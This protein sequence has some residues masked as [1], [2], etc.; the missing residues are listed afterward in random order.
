M[1]NKNSNIKQRF[2][3]L[4]ILLGF[5]YS[6]S[7]GQQ[8]V[9]KQQ[10]YEKILTAASQ[11]EKYI[12]QLKNKKIGLV[13]NQTSL[14]NDSVHL[15]DYLLN[16]NINVVKIFSPEHGFR[17][18]AADGEQ[19]MNSKDVKTGLPIVSLYGATKK[20]T[21][22]MLQGLDLIIFDIQDVGT[23]F[24]TYI[25]TMHYVM[26][27]CAPRGIKVMILDRPNP[28]GFYVD[29]P[30]ME[31]EFMS[32]VGMHK[33]P[34]VH[35]MT[36][37]ELAMMVNGEGWLTDGKQ[38]NLEVITVANYDHDSRYSLP[39]R[40]SPNLPNDKAINLYPSICLFEGT[41]FSLGRGTDF[42][43]QVL[44]YPDE[45]YGDFQFTP[46]SIP[47]VS[48]Y[49]PQENKLCY[50]VDL[51][52]EKELSSI[53]LTYLIDFYKMWD[54]D[55]PF[56]KK[57]FDQLAGSA[58]LR[59]QIKSGMSEEEI[60]KTWQAGLTEFKEKRKKYLLYKDF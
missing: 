14:V 59:E 15:V 31:E 28:N 56:F 58:T 12:L 21:P 5:F 48:T 36:V 47:G 26:D 29:G 11:P 38:C 53:S 20:P 16:E 19:V 25:S 18:E 50:G 45:K 7:S 43:F 60:K 57:Y 17:G 39:V 46:V 55:E 22:E 35:G 27:A 54:K 34:I 32:F 3:I 49:P 24:Y 52:N 9:E 51:R 33:I 37:G 1:Q 42:P 2:L 23:R 40:P 6:C 13:V 44:G 41:K 8:A 10:T 30:I 4:T